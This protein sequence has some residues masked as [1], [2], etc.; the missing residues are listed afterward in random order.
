ML[1]VLMSG[2]EYPADG[3]VSSDSISP[4][5]IVLNNQGVALMGQYDYEAARGIFETLVEQE[6]DWLQARV[7]LAI[8][9]LNRQ[10][11]GDEHTALSIVTQVLQKD[12]EQ[13]RALYVSGIIH[14]YIGEPEQAT[15]FFN[16]VVTRDA[17][18]A[19][20]VYFLGQSY[21][22]MGDYEQSAQ[23]LLR[24]AELDPYLRSAYWAGAQVLRRLG[25]IEDSAEMLAGY[26]RFGPNPAARL[27]AISYKRMG[28]KAEALSV[29]TEESPA[30]ILPAGPLFAEPQLIDDRIIGSTVTAVDLTGDSILDIVV[31]TPA[32]LT[33]D[34]ILDIV[35]TTPADLTGDSILDI[36]VTTP[37]D[38]TGDSI[39]DIVV[40]TPAGMVVYSGTESGF[41]S[42]DDH[43]LS[44]ETADAA[45]WGDMNDDGS[46]DVVLCDDRGSRL[47]LQTADS[48]DEST[49]LSAKPCKAGAVFD[50]DHDGDLD[51][52]TTGPLGNELLSNNRDGTFRELAAEM[53]LFGKA[54]RQVLVA[55][56]DADRDLD[57]VVINEDSAND[58]WQNDRTWQYR[59]FPGLEDLRNTSLVAATHA[60]AD[61]DGHVEIYGM[62]GQ[63]ELLAWRFDGSAWQ[64]RLMLASRP[65]KSGELTMA[66]FDGD[67]LPELLYNHGSGF[68]VV[69]PRTDKIVMEQP[70][71]GLVT[72]IVLTRHPGKG[73]GIVTISRQGMSWWPAGP[74][75]YEFLAVSPTG[76]S[77]SDQMRSNASG[78][79][80]L[81]KLRT[82]ARWSVAHMLDAHSGPGQSLAPVSIGLGGRKTADYIAL[83][84]S[85]GVS[86]TE[87]DLAAG[88]LHRI[89]E[90]QRQLSS[91]PVIFAWDGE[92]W[93]FVSDVLGVGGLGFFVSPGEY[94]EPR[95][96]EKFLLDEGMLVESNGRYLIKF[97]EPMEENAYLDAAYIQ[98]YDVPEG[99]SLVMDE[100][101]GILGKR[102]TGRPITYRRSLNPVRATDSS[103]NDVLEKV[104]TA[105][106]SAPPPGA[107]DPRFVGLLAKDQVI[108]LEFD[109]VIDQPGAVLVADGWVE[110]P[111]SQTVFAAWQAGLQYQAA[112]LAARDSTGQWHTVAS[113]FGYPAGMPRK[114]AL[115][116]SSLPSG[117]DALRLTSNME[118]Y[119]DRL[120]VVF[121]E[122]LDTVRAVTLRPVIAGVAKTGFALRTN[123]PQ[124]VPR[125][126][127]AIRSPYWDTKFQRGFYTAL[128]DATPLVTDT[129]GALAI[130]GSGEEVHLEFD[131]L[132]APPTGMKRHFVL[133]FR[134]W[135]KDMDLYTEHGETV[136]PLP[137]I[138][139]IDRDRR[140]SL[141]ARY[142]VRFQ[143]GL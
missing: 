38:L 37:A 143:E 67:G 77:E 73:P 127:Y 69:N 86:Q 4:E 40:T 138:E 21:L 50:A 137:E 108:T 5:N 120:Q 125:Y 121:E 75:R 119:W 103:N 53:G 118:I 34:S 55:D 48:F 20:A 39:L 84:W 45:M 7:N 6:P 74:G 88:E 98:V 100:R 32:D 136:G 91:C 17:Q 47:V 12:P 19:Y 49:T 70:V 59:E 106:L 102:V 43:P 111:Y 66:D 64:R 26:Q 29:I 101:M 68:I 27:A 89:A 35:V 123:G 95:P 24:A 94:G 42:N 116:L 3:I 85:D 36:V 126:D 114:M 130:I 82:G 115:P 109:Q 46:V 10:K 79:G 16:R 112:T 113:E 71:D 56:L 135:T 96:Y 76:R 87:L 92:S 14:F 25:R 44:T 139:G 133:D 99:W 63:G 140:E 134:G 124:K 15:A 61:A 51:L 13:I 23:W 107:V 22:Q 132:P 93:R 80:T 11:E 57:I 105:D 142:N 141:H 117:T 83:E 122:P 18:D 41:T 78:I 129:D 62:T 128:G 31:T 110:Y 97:T 28:P 33:G 104:L 52:Y 131:A 30:A 58:I 54:G 72:A 65:D 8:A 60:D 90:K 9:F 2:C 81:I 1:I